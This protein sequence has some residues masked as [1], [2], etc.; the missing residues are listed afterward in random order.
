MNN[1]PKEMKCVL[2]TSQTCLSGHPGTAI[3]SYNRT[4]FFPTTV[5]ISTRNG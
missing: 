1:Q 5:Y 4:F 3:C 2:G